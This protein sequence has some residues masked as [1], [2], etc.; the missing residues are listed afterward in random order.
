MIKY[1]NSRDI[2]FRSIGYQE[3]TSTAAAVRIDSITSKLV[4]K[5]KDASHFGCLKCKAITT[6]DGDDLLDLNGKRHFCEDPDRMDHEEKCV[7]Q[8]QKIIEYYNRRELSSFQ[9]GLKMDD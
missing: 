8:I 6:L 4:K 7:I 3:K 2:N 1:T 9:L 5:E